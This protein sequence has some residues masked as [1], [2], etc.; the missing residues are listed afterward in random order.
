[1]E[2]RFSL[3]ERAISLMKMKK[4]ISQWMNSEEEVAPLTKEIKV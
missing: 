4:A 2:A 3:K 1:M